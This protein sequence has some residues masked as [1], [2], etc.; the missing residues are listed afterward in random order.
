VV[1]MKLVIVVIVLSVGR[2]PSLRWGLYCNETP[3]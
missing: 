2:P 3:F 1:S